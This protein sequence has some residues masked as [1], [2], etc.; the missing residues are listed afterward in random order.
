MESVY[1]IA[2]ITRQSYFKEKYRLERKSGQE[3]LTREMIE[4][5][6]SEH[7]QMG[8]RPM[9]YLL[10]VDTMGIN[11]FEK[12]VSELGLGIEK[13][14]LWMKTTNSNHNYYKYPNLI[15][16]LELTGINQLWVSDITYWIDGDK[17]Y[18][19]TFMMDVYSRYI[20]GYAVSDS[21]K[22]INNEFVLEMA[23]KCR[24]EQR[25]PGLIHHS[26]KGSQY[27]ST[28]YVDRLIEADIQISMANNSIENP[29]AE[30]LNGTIK[31]S[32]LV[33]YDTRTFNKLKKA[34]KRIVWLYNNE[35]PHMELGYLTPAEYERKIACIPH[36]KRNP[37]ILFDYS[38]E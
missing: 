30:R 5:V 22:A 38:K 4:K 2:G 21:L 1:K 35:K 12:L 9:Y 16:G 18:Y 26:D 23:F 15:Y 32:Y 10:K 25:Y 7:P 27:C 13:K 6:R 20:L 36:E 19:L 17:T 8:S 29:Y 3:H 28:C 31:N 24:G 11:K 33:F 34:L 37:M 14:K